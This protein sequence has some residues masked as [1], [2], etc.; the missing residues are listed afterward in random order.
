MSTSSIVIIGAKEHNLKNIS[1]EIPKNKLVV[2]TGLSG[3]GKSS[4]A[5]DTIYAEGQR[6]YIESLSS[7]ARQF[8]GQMEKPDVESISG[9]S[10][11]I[12]IDQKGAPKNPRSTVGTITEI[13]DYLRVLFARVG[14]IYCPNCKIEI[15]SLSID[16]IVDKIFEIG[17]G[18]KIYILA[19]LVSGRKGEYEG[20]LQD[21]KKDGFV[22]I[23]VDGKIM[24]IPERLN[25]AK[26]KKHNIEV[27]VDRVVVKEED[28]SRI[29]ASSETALKLGQGI[30]QIIVDEKKVITFSEKFSCATCGFSYGE[31]HPRMFSF[32]SPYGAC[33]ACSG[34]GQKLEIDPNLVVWDKEKSISERGILPWNI[35]SSNYYLELVKSAAEHYGISLYK[36]IKML[37]QHELNLLL[38]GSH[39]PA[40]V[41][42][43]FRNRTGEKRVAHAYFQGIIP[44]LLKKYK[45]AT[46]EYL[47]SE[48]EKYMSVRNCEECGGTR[49]KKEVLSITIDGKSI[50]DVT[51]LSIRDL[52][53]FFKNLKLSQKKKIISHQ[54][55]KEIMQ[56]CEFLLNVGLDYITLSRS[57]QTLAG[58]EHQRIR[59]ATQIGSGLQGV[60]YIFDEPSIGLHPRDNERLIETLKKLRDIGN[61]VIVIEHDESMIKASDFI[62]DLGPGAGREGG[63]VVFSGHWKEILKCERSLTGKYLSKSLTI[64]IPRTRRK[65][66]K[67][68]LI[69]NARQ[70]N[71]KNI[72][73]KIPLE[74]F[75]CITGVSGS[76]KSTLLYEILYK[77]LIQKLHGGTFDKP[78]EFDG[79]EGVENID[80]V[81]LVDQ[82]PIGRTPRSNPAT[83]TKT[84][85]LIRDLFS[86]THDAKMRGYKPG[87][88]SFNVKGG[89]CESCEGD[90]LLKIEMHFLPD[91]YITC[92]TCKGKRYN[93]ETLQVRYKGKNIA[94]VLD[95]TVEE[96]LHF[97]ENI[98]KIKNKLQT[99]FDVGLGYIQLGQPATTLSGGEA[100]RIK[101]AAE[102]SR[103]QTSKTLYIL[104]EPTTGLHFADIEKLLIILHR[105]VDAK[106]TV[107]VIEHNLEVIKV[108]D[109]IIDLGPEGGDKG[110]YLVAEGTP[111]DVAKVK[112]SYTGQ[113]LRKVLNSG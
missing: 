36:P 5:Y 56:R 91:V 19:P 72:D 98:T 38:Y 42:V 47:R 44:A 90:G 101:L 31:I 95:M 1:L 64:P 11:A 73:V 51:E 16:Q 87:R 48:I 23:R 35:T 60:L 80:K 68:L 106:N 69:K 83:Y 94:D 28:R 4:L 22:R 103:P 39:K 27:V 74:V 14:D 9:L 7:Y 99:L 3:S 75:C 50:A 41:K 107:I 49:L 71:L 84:F 37:S 54:V 53:E 30:M 24:E 18:K 25:L 82:S 102:L 45:E 58:G 34:I 92:D 61:T 78:G 67:Y 88:F 70:F 10:P 20:L 76:G 13:Y 33:P 86:Q 59:L 66:Q 63:E 29:F 15:S 110:G 105:L 55:I 77:A 85:D 6:R 109:Y 112:A 17:E 97:F 8:L 21:I 2:I 57:S 108:A 79:I 81:I 96:A 40:L 113:F 104:D 93:Q 26:Y 65:P 52:Y 62:V 43:Y 12:S 111:E 89:R 32:N 46:S 100:Q